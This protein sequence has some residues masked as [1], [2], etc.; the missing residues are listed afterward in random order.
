MSRWRG[1]RGAA[2]AMSSGS[3]S[4][5]RTVPARRTPWLP[6]WSA[7]SG[8]HPP[9]R[10]RPSECSRGWPAACPPRTCPPCGSTRAGRSSPETAGAGRRPCSSVPARRRESTASRS[11]RPPATRRTASSRPR[12]RCGL[13]RWRGTLP[14]CGDAARPRRSPTARSSSWCR[15]ASWAACRPGAHCPIRSAAWPRRRAA[16]PTPRR[17]GSSTRCWRS[18]RRVRRP[19]GSGVAA[20]RR[21]S[22]WA[23]RRRRCGARCSSCSPR[24][25]TTATVST[26]GGWICSTRPARWTR[27]SCQ[28]TGSRLSR[29]RCTAPPAGLA[30]S[31]GMPA[32]AGGGRARRPSSLRSCHGWP[33]GSPPTATRWPRGSSATAAAAWTQASS[34]PASRSASHSPTP[35]RAT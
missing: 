2:W 19:R 27:S 31:C 4:T 26:A 30:A 20:A 1:R 24:P 12:G 8:W 6:R 32:R 5:T 9:G 23:G 14:T 11:T 22:A 18:P 13:A 29:H 21:W 15:H 16:S 28:P 34:T 33:L 35:S 7:P 3:W 17:S 10:G 25:A